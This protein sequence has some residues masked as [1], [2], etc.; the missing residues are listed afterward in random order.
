VVLQGKLRL[1]VHDA[2]RNRMALATMRGPFEIWDTAEGKRLS[3]LLGQPRELGSLTF[4]PNG[5]S[6]IAV[7][8]FRT[9]VPLGVAPA[10]VIRARVCNIQTG[11]LAWTFPI[12]LP[13]SA[14]D[15]QIH[16]LD[17]RTLFVQVANALAGYGIRYSYGKV[18]IL[19]GKWTTVDAPK[20]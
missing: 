16:W 20:D 10:V 14:A 12:A 4:S 7:D 9:R 2:N 18:D 3:V 5:K 6:F 13:A 1:V 15:C 8:D 17:E 11:E 19:T